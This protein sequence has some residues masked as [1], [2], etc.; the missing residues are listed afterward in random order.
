MSLYLQRLLD[1]AAALPPPVVSASPLLVSGSPVLTFDQRLA[2]AEMADDFSIL[3]A[4]PELPEASEEALPPNPPPARQ[5]APGG[6]PT[7][8]RAAVEARADHPSPVPP[9]RSTG[10]AAADL[11]LPEFGKAIEPADAAPARPRKV[12]DASAVEP[13]RQSWPPRLEPTLPPAQPVPV[14]ADPVRP[15]LQSR[16]PAEPSRSSA[17]AAPGPATEE[18]AIRDRAPQAE[19][20]PAPAPPKVSEAR[21]LPWANAAVAEA[22]HPVPEATSAKSAPAAE[23]VVAAIPP[24]APPPRGLSAR[25]V[26]RMIA[27]AIGAERERSAARQPVTARAQPAQT[28][29]PQGEAPA[30]RP[31]TAAQAS[32]IGSLESSRFR[33]M[34]FGVRR[35]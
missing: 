14:H 34:L 32:L 13:P 33:P 10:P 12:P 17:E 26:E 9:S 25:E 3:G 6:A 11:T 23:P 7:P 2:S 16:A 22:P 30:R 35:R 5:N 18:A 1:R 15:P 31:A 21:P 20:S 29:A 8:R 24:L 28:P 19:P 4:T 27:E